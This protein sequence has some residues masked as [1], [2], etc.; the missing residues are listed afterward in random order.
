MDKYYKCLCIPQEFYQHDTPTLLTIIESSTAE[1]A[2]ETIYCSGFKHHFEVVYETTG[3]SARIHEVEASKRSQT[4]LVAAVDL[5]DGQ[6]KEL[7]LCYNRKWVGERLANDTHKFHASFLPHP[8]IP[9]T[10]RS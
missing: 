7:L 10:S 3:H 6:E 2:N 1:K 5:C 4:Q 8:Q 9:V